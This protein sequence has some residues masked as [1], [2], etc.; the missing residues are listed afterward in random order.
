MYHQTG[1]YAVRKSTRCSRKGRLTVLTSDSPREIGTSK[2]GLIGFVFCPS[3]SGICTITSFSI[4]L[5]AGLPA[6][7]L[8]LFFQ[9]EFFLDT[10]LHRLTLIFVV[11]HSREG[12]NPRLI[13]QFPNQL[14]LFILLSCLL[15]SFCYLLYERQ[16]KKAGIF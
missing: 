5:H 10:D 13:L 14:T 1:L 7:K 11:C 9:I 15:Y 3:Q 16:F 6:G 2:L 8:A 4:R 12:G